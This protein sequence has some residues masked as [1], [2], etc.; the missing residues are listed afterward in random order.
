MTKKVTSSK[1]L[2]QKDFEHAQKVFKL[3]KS[4]KWNSAL[5]ASEKVK[6]KE[7]KD[8]VKWMYLKTTGNSASF[9]DYQKF[10]ERNPDYPRIGRLQILS[11]T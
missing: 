6:N 11:G 9:N 8:L 2:G 4:R 7:F 10:I 1:I 3:I 5:K